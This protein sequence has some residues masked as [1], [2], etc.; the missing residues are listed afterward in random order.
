M[1]RL[2]LTG[3]A[4]ALLGAAAVVSPIYAQP[5]PNGPAAG[6]DKDR[7][8]AIRDAFAQHPAQNAA[9]EARR[10]Q[11]LADCEAG[12]GRASDQGDETASGAQPGQAGSSDQGGQPQPGMPGEGGSSSSGPSSAPVSMAAPASSAMGTIAGPPSTLG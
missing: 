10:Q 9:A 5:Q 8:A 2:I 7:C 6:G 3:A 12:K 1:S 4:I 11:R